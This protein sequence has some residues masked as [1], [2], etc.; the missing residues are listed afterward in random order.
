MKSPAYCL[1]ASLRAGLLFLIAAMVFS[2][3]VARAAAL[4][5]A[6]RQEDP[7]LRQLV[8]IDSSSLFLA[9][10][11]QRLTKQTGVQIALSGEAAGDYRICCA[12]K[13]RPLADVMDAVWSLMSYR[14][15]EWHWERRKSAAG[16]RNYLMRTLPARRL[17][18]ELRNLID[19]Q[20]DQHYEKMMRAVSSPDDPA[21][22]ADSVEGK[23]LGSARIRSGLQLFG[24][25][26][27]TE[28]RRAVL[29]GGAIHRIPVGELDAEGR[30][31]VQGIWQKS[32]NPNSTALLPRPEWLEFRATRLGSNVS[33]SLF[34]VLDGLGGYAYLG[35][36][37]LE[38]QTH[39]ALDERWQLPGDLQP[40]QAQELKDLRLA[41]PGLPE[42]LGLPHTLQVRKLAEELGIP[43][44]AYL[45]RGRGAVRITRPA[46]LPHLLQQLKSREPYLVSKVRNGVLLLRYRAWFQQEEDPPALTW[47]FCR[48]ARGILG[49][50]TALPLSA[51]C[52]V[53]SLSTIPQLA[54]L[55]E[56][57]PLM[58]SVAYW[59]EPLALL[60]R[61]ESSRRRLLS[62]KGIAL[63]EMMGAVSGSASTGLTRAL[64]AGRFSTLRIEIEREHDPADWVLTLLLGGDNGEETP[65]FRLFPPM[66]EGVRP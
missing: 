49:E 55:A 19:G 3:G 35:G 40:E 61:S 29:S 59:R 9:E 33:P 42:P 45:P 20:F 6:A 52:R 63:R 18:G 48:K 5:A 7:R 66:R 27:P 51:Y 26:V 21:P 36:D 31:F 57:Y 2:P 8:T 11:A 34:I 15:A 53:A 38:K 37:P 58:G 28:T 14:N 65:V 30:D 43:I 25:L 10:L 50:E 44:F 62:H 23:L 56:D 13:A 4:G 12:V 22:P 46:S 16:F 47:E 39:G 60:A 24:R 1:G 41:A 54:A 17:A 64:T 32:M